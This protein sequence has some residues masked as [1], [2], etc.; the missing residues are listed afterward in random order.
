MKTEHEVKESIKEVFEGYPEGLIELMLG[1][2][3]M[4]LDDEEQEP[5]AVSV[6]YCNELPHGE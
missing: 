3:E 2:F 1:T 5:T 6:P 4:W